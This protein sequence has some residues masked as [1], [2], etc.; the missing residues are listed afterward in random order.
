MQ[1]PMFSAIGSSSFHLQMVDVGSTGQITA[2]ALS[3]L[4]KQ[5]CPRWTQPTWPSVNFVL[6]PQAQEQGPIPPCLVPSP[7]AAQI[8]FRSR[9]QPA[10]WINPGILLPHSLLISLVL[11]SVCPLEN[12]SDLVPQTLS[13]LSPPAG[14][15]SKTRFVDALAAVQ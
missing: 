13:W 10:G 8:R 11:L 1:T 5:L 6:F 15:P 12:S 4:Y 7:S 3:L 9:P 14:N 2:W